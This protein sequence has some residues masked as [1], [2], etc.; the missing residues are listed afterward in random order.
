MI[1]NLGALI[2]DRATE[3]EDIRRLRDDVLQRISEFVLPNRGD[4]TIKRAKGSRTD[5]NV[6]D[7]TGVHA[8]RTLAA[9]LG[10]MLTPLDG[11]WLGLRPSQAALEEVQGVK[12]YLA[13]VEEILLGVFSSFEFGFPQQNDQIFIDMPAYGTSCMFVEDNIDNGLTFQAIHLSEI[14]FMESAKG[15]PDIVFRK[16]K[17]TARQA[18]DKFGEENLGHKVTAALK[19]NPFTEFEFIHAVMPIADWKKLGRVP[20]VNKTDFRFPSAYVCVEDKKIVMEKGYHEMPYIISRWSKYTG[21]VYGRG[22]GWDTL[23]DIMMANKLK[24]ITIRGAEKQIDPPLILSDDGVVTPLRTYPNGI[25]IGAVTQDGKPLVQQLPVNGRIDLA[26]FLLKQTQE[27]IRKGFFVDRFE[28][29]DGTPISATESA[30]RQDTRLR[31]SAPHIQRIQ[32]EYLSQLVERVFGILQRAG[33]LPEP[34]QELAGDNLK[35]EFVSPLVKAQRSQEALSYSRAMEASMGLI[36]MNPDLVRNIDMDDAFR[37]IL[38]ISGVPVK[39]I[40]S[41]DKVLA[42]RQAEQEA[43]EQ[44]QMLMQ[45]Q[46][47]MGAVADAKNK[48]LDIGI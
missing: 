18:A 14:F 16:F 46:E 20:N 44:Q 36:Q 45:A 43:Q 37:D 10:T 7:T 34:P 12:E 5:R 35:I 1:D 25:N 8:N 42:E 47:T 3:A 22:P 11:K 40:K 39:N 31:L 30:D 6:F 29:K 33:E 27:S 9:A 13:T 21:E 19:K 26:E 15:K 2:L 32:A 23:A 17:L 28:E 48:G 24:E 4:F 38:E 41:K